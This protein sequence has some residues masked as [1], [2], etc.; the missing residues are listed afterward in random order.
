MPRQTQ[1][2]F[3]KAQKA[4]AWAYRSAP[5]VTNS[6]ARNPILKLRS[7]SAHGAE[8]GELHLQ[9]DDQ[10]R[11]W[12]TTRSGGKTGE[13]GRDLELVAI[14]RVVIDGIRTG[15]RETRIAVLWVKWED[16]IAY[17][18]SCGFVRE[19]AWRLLGPVDVDLVLG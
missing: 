9:T 4:S 8:I 10:L 7:S 17:R 6:T 16:G 2:L 12:S 15:E 5:S 14:S 1:Y 11:S 18:Q 19:D 13:Q 3:A